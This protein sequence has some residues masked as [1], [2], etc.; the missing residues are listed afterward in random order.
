[1][2]DNKLD[3]DKTNDI[4]TLVGIGMLKR[5]LN[6]QLITE[7]EYEKMVKDFKGRISPDFNNT[8]NINQ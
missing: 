1:M 8:N 7:I 5:M 4:G 2:I 3:S 6:A